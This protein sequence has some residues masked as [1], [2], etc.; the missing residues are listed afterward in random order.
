[1]GLTELDRAPGRSV[2]QS[3]VG[4]SVVRARQLRVVGGRP[5]RDPDLD[6]AVD[7]V[8][9]RRLL[10]IGAHALAESRRD[11][12]VRSV[13]VEALSRAAVGFSRDVEALAAEDPSNPDLWLWLGRTRVEEAW[14]IRPE[15][16]ARAVQAQSYTTYTKSMQSAREP[17][18]RA[19]SLWPDDPVPW[20]AMLWYALGLGLER[21]DKD[22][23]WLQA[24]RRCPT[25]YGAHVARVVSLSPQWGGMTDE[26]FGFARTAMS[27]APREDP[28]AALIP[29]AYFEYFVQERSGMIRGRPRGSLRRSAARWRPPRGAG[30]RGAVSIPG[31]SRRTT[32]SAPRSTSP[33]RA[34]RRGS[35]R[36]GRGG[37][38]A[39]FPGRIWE[40][41][42]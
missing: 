8:R 33:T 21:E 9:D 24:S 7:A 13:R 5:W 35:I 37:G 14:R 29:L 1:M 11:P 17:L 10:R 27:M 15:A 36:S 22:A 41:T 28:R 6:W 31:R 38:R 2:E 40:A 12:E 18:M 3:G 32:S 30:S 4:A 16:R 39:A 26:M 42:R 19:A 23:L 20:E 25:L 34:G